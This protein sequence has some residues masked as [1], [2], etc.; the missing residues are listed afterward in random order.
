MRTDRDRK[1]EPVATTPVV[2]N[3]ILFC[4]EREK[5]TRNESKRKQHFL[6]HKGKH[7]SS[8]ESY[9][10]G[11]KSTGRKVGYIAVFTDTTRT[12]ALPE[13]ASIHTAEMTVTCKNQRLTIK[14]C[15]Q[16]CP[17]WREKAVKWRK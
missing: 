14:H 17:Q 8:E 9:I 13:E 3:N 16:N 1:D 2:G 5:H 4:Y 12:G 10:D 11:S 15:F 6:Q 7:G